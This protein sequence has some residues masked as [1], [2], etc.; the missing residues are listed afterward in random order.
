MRAC[1]GVSPPNLHTNPVERWEIQGSKWPKSPSDWPKLSQD[2]KPGITD[3]LW[4]KFKNFPYL[5]LGFVEWTEFRKSKRRGEGSLDRGRAG[6][7]AQ[8]Q[9]SIPHVQESA[10]QLGLTGTWSSWR[11]A[12]GTRL[13]YARG[14]HSEVLEWRA[15]DRTLSSRDVQELNLGLSHSGCF[16]RDVSW[17]WSKMASWTRH[18][19]ACFMSPL[20][21]E[22][23]TSLGLP[24]LLNEL[25]KGRD[26]CFIRCYTPST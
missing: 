16:S 26:G 19:C 20:L 7:K 12:V 8:R 5:K 9:E 14:S 1:H 23:H 21:R 2:L 10:H 15:T 24:C 4:T 11:E 17:G 3:L 18:S 13:K 6:A 25:H 22:T